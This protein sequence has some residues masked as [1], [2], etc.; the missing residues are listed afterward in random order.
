MKNDILDGMRLFEDIACADSYGRTFYA[1]TDGSYLLQT[2]ERAEI[3]GE[4]HMIHDGKID[5][6]SSDGE[7]W[8]IKDIRRN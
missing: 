1:I 6:I 2:D 8:M 7:V 4:A 5:Q 3:R